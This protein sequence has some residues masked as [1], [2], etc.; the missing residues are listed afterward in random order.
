MQMERG[1]RME[2]SNELVGLDDIVECI[3]CF[4]LG[5]DGKGKVIKLASQSGS[6]SL[7]R[8]CNLFLCTNGGDDVVSP[9]DGG[10]YDLCGHK[11]I[12]YK[13]LSVTCSQKQRV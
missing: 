2:H 12:S 5:D 6:E 13:R 11:A 3:T 1:C 7:L 10:Y 8:L 9:F 4:N